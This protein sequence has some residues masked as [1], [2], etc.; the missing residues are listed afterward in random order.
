VTAV[1]AAFRRS[2]GVLTNWYLEALAMLKSADPTSDERRK[3][4]AMRKS[5]DLAKFIF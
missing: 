4:D 5:A 3:F 2:P 1:D